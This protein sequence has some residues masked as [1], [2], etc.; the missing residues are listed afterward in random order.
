MTMTRFVYGMQARRARRPHLPCRPATSLCLSLVADESMTAD[1][2]Q[3]LDL[4][5]FLAPSFKGRMTWSRTK[6]TAFSGTTLQ[7]RAT[8]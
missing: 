3:R 8:Q 4:G 6:A 1:G 2:I 5:R 7:G